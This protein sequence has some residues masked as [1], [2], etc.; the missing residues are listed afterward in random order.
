MI[1]EKCRLLATIRSVLGKNKVAKGGWF[2]L[3]SIHFIKFFSLQAEI[4]FDRKTVRL[5]IDQPKENSRELCGVSSLAKWWERRVT[6]MTE[7]QFQTQRRLQGAGRRAGIFIRASV[8]LMMRSIY[9][10][11]IKSAF[12]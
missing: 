8:S 5:L 11:W 9:P 2:S 3:Q 4:Y 1:A 10:V 6:E 7:A 12:R